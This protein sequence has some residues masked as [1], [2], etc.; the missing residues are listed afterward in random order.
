VN[1]TEIEMTKQRIS[2]LVRESEKFVIQTPVDDDIYNDMF[3]CLQNLN[4]NFL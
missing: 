2:I 1:R 3:G 4:L